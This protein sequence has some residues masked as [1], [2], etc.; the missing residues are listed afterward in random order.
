MRA[1]T[2]P[3]EVLK[4]EYMKPYGLTNS[5]LAEMLDV[6]EGA[7]SRLINGKASMSTEMA[8]RLGKVFGTTPMFWM[9]LQTTY[10]VSVSKEDK[11]LQSELDKLKPY[12]KRAVTELREDAQ[13][14]S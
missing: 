12:F 5:K 10:D 6:N 2:T 9:N 13:I 1:I 8:L 7:M 4:Q 11:V 3:G 14:D